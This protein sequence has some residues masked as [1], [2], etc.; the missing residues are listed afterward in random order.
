M[1]TMCERLGSPRVPALDT[2][3]PSDE[4]LRQVN[5]L[6]ISCDRTQAHLRNGLFAG[7]FC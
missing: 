7:I 2:C 3:S 5:E 1:R 6:L 4:A